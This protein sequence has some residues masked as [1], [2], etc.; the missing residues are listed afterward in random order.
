[1]FK[2]SWESFEVVTGPL[3]SPPPVAGAT[4]SIVLFTL[5]RQRL[6]SFRLYSFCNGDQLL[7]YT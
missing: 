7:F 3:M 2:T 5:S 4:N 6:S 1:M